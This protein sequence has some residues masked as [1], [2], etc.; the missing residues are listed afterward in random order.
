MGGRVAS[1]LAGDAGWP[2]AGMV[3]YGYPLMAIKKRE[4]RATT[5]LRNIEAPQLFFAGSRDRLS[6]PDL[7]QTLTDSLAD[8]TAIIVDGGDHSFHVPKRTGR[9]HQEVIA[10]L[11]ARTATWMYQ[12]RPS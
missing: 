7:I 2:A 12:P 8:A 4:P 5:H 10:E 9:S 11:A 6:P 3:Y 1:H